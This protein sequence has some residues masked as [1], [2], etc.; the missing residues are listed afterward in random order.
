MSGTIKFGGLN[1]TSSS[2]DFT[3]KDNDAVSLE[4]KSSDGGLY[5]TLDTTDAAEN[6]Q[7][8]QQT[9]III[10]DKSVTAGS[11][12]HMVDVS[13]MILT[14]TSTPAAGTAT[15]ANAIVINGPTLGAG[16]INVTTTDAATLQ[17]SGAPI[18]G[19]NQTLTNPH[20]VLID[21]KN[22]KGGALTVKN[23]TTQT[24][25]N[26][27][28]ITG[29]SGQTALN[30]AAGDVSINDNLTVLGDTI[31][32][33]STEDAIGFYGAAAI[34]QPT[35]GVNEADFVENDGGPAG[36]TL[37]NNDSTF[38]GYTL[39]QLVQALQNLGLLA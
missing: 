15:E 14:D 1:S 29:A 16:G 19:T 2:A 20:A 21:S 8:N 7:F 22:A 32:G 10:G 39:Q 31:L 9:K 13:T 18:Q 3:L 28:S 11:T 5:M 37:V 23:T 27:V 6:I 36:V 33:N 38:G 4:L 35:T 34:V 26:L 30:V 24:S 25:G 12:G 17:I